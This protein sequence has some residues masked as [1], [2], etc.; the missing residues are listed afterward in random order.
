VAHKANSFFLHLVWSSAATSASSIYMS[1]S[2][3]SREM[4]WLQVVRGLPRPLLPGSFQFM[5]CFGSLCAF[6]RVRYWYH[7]RCLWC[8]ERALTCL[9][10]YA[11][12]TYFVLPPYFM[13]APKVSGVEAV[14][15]FFH[16]LVTTHVTGWHFECHCYSH[17]DLHWW[18]SFLTL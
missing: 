4:V 18:C 9:L 6:M 8:W 11:W 10:P 1:R 15:P 14:H 2:L 16:G 17:S 13:D 3:R 5:A 7:V 12:G